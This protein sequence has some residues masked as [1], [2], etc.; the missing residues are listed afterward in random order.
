MTRIREANKQYNIHIVHITYLFPL[1]KFGKRKVFTVRK[2][3]SCDVDKVM[4]ITIFVRKKSGWDR[5]HPS[6]RV[7]RLCASV[8]QISSK[9]GNPRRINDVI[10]IFKMAAAAAPYYFRF[11]IWWRR[12][13]PKV[14]IYLQT[15]FRPAILIHSWDIT[16]SGLEKQPSAILKFYFRFRLWPYHRTRH[17]L[18]PQ[19]ACHSAR[20]WNF[21]QI[22]PPTA[23]KWRHVHFQDGGSLPS[24]ILGIQIQ[25]WVLWKG[26]VDTTSYRSSSR[27]R[28]SKLLSFEKIAFFCIL[29]TDRQ[30]DKQMDR[31]I[32][33]SRCRCRE[34]RLNKLLVRHTCRL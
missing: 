12:S 26:Y 21:I 15:K 23:E 10:Y 33:L 7:R 1:L 22:G 17:R 9:S 29:A 24:W 2:L 18:S 3:V 34:G 32:A 25:L 31:P 28:S 20:V 14:K 19:S 27:D 30:S 5:S 11:R 4:G 13:H 16:T 6:P 8:Y